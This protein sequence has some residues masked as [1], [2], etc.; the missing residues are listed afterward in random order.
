MDLRKLET[1]E[2]VT[3]ILSIRDFC[4]AQVQFGLIDWCNLTHRLGATQSTPTIY[5]YIY[6][7]SLPLSMPISMN[8]NC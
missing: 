2:G 7:P 4:F 3:G 8:N 5:I 1:G 6:M